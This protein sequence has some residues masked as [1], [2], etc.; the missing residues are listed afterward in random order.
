MFFRGW[1]AFTG[2]MSVH[3]FFLSQCWC[4][5]VLD[6]YTKTGSKISDTSACKKCELSILSRNV[7]PIMTTKRFFSLFL[8]SCCSHHITRLSP[9]LSLHEWPPPSP[10][11]IM[12]HSSHASTRDRGRMRAQRNPRGVHRL[13]VAIW[14]A[15]WPGI[16]STDE[17][18]AYEWVLT[19]C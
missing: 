1:L 19:K 5:T 7:M 13:Q 11:V 9:S 14:V 6:W 3:L 10:L 18:T 8:V 4:D 15:Q 17:R 2:A 12:P 16:T